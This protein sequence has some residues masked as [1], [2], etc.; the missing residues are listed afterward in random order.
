MTDGVAIVVPEMQCSYLFDY[1]LKI[2][3]MSFNGM[4]NVPL[5]W[6]ELNAWV[7]VTGTPLDAWELKVI[8]KASEVYVNQLELSRKIDAPMPQK[9]VEQDPRKL[10]KHIKSILR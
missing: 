5:S 8:H 10:A 2:G 9:I 4:A 7:Q 1:L 3:V 6:Q